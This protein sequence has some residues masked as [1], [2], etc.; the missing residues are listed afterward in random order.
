MSDSPTMVEEAV[1]EIEG[2]RHPIIDL[3]LAEGE[4][5]VANNTSMNV[6]VYLIH[7]GTRVQC[8]GILLACKSY[9]LGI[10]R[11]IQIC[12]CFYRAL[13]CEL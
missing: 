3:L 5:Y 4:Q 13:K 10:G 12:C 7:L 11:I 8:N 2:G 9:G 6:Y 1:V